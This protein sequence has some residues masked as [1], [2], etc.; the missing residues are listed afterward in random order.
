M[1]KMTKNEIKSV[2]MQV[3]YEVNNFNW[4]QY[5]QQTGADNKADEKASRRRAAVETLVE[6]A[7]KFGCKFT[8]TYHRYCYN[9]MYVEYKNNT[10]LLWCIEYRNDERDIAH[11]FYTHLVAE[12]APT[13]VGSEFK[14]YNDEYI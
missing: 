8:F 3:W 1:R 13:F 5:R 11:E 12:K 10:Y 4:Y 14:P 7:E 9:T 2:I 6:L